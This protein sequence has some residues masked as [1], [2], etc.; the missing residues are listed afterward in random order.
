MI[1]LMLL[2]KKEWMILIDILSLTVI[3]DDIAASI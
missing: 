2:F 3:H 1:I